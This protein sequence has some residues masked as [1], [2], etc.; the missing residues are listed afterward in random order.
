MATD[1]ENRRACNR[2]N[3]RVALGM[4]LGTG[5]G[6]AL[7]IAFDAVFGTWSR[8]M[9][10]SGG[11]VVGM[12]LGIAF[13]EVGSGAPKIENPKCYKRQVILSFALGGI[14]LLLGIISLGSTS[15][16]GRIL[17]MGFL[18]AAIASLVIGLAMARRLS[19]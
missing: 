16:I 14:V 13:A 18:P 6:V 5:L 3:N 15:E 9:G 10:M 7:G 17:A 4:T 19:R 12:A 8:G 11:V 2:H 1:D